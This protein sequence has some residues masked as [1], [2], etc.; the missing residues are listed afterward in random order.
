MTAGGRG[1]GQRSIA[2]TQS[3]S[4]FLR[5]LCLTLAAKERL[6]QLETFSLRGM[7]PQRKTN[8]SKIAA[9]TTEATG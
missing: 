3:A 4:R 9:E 5:S 1:L 6:P 8:E 7:G 2:R